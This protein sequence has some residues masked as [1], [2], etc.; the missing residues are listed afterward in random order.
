MPVNAARWSVLAEEAKA[1]AE[2]MKDALSKKTML[3][4]AA[5]YDRLAK[6]APAAKREAAQ[7]PVP[8]QR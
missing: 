3:E 6:R 7:Q 1:I 8:P 5:G 4:I 2:E